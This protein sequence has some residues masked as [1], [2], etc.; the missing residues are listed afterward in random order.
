MDHKPLL[1]RLAP[2]SLAGQPSRLLARV[3]IS[4]GARTPDEVEAFLAPLPSIPNRLAAAQHEEVLSIARRI[5]D[6]VRRNETIVIFADYDADGATSAVILYDFLTALGAAPA[7][8]LPH[9]INEGYGLTSSAAIR[10]VREHH[11]DLLIAVDCGTNSTDAID[12]LRSEYHCDTIVIDHHS[13]LDLQRHPGLFLNPKLSP[14]SP[15]SVRELSA[16]GLT[17]LLV[18]AILPTAS[19]TLPF[20]RDRAII[21]AGIGTFVD[22]M[23]LTAINRTLVKNALTLLN[24]ASGRD[25]IPGIAAVLEEASSPDVDSWTLAFLLGPILNA[26]GRI[27]NAMRTIALLTACDRSDVIPLATACVATNE[28][29]KQIQR[30]ILEEAEIDAT[31]I[32]KNCPTT[33]ILVV[34]RAH[35]HTGIV[36]IVAARL[37]ERFHR[38]AIVLGALDD[39]TGCHWKGS[40]RSINGYDIGTAITNAVNSGYATTGGGHKMAGGIEVPFAGL[41]RLRKHLN[42]NCGLTDADLVPRFDVLPGSPQMIERDWA[43]LFESLEPFGSGNARP[44][45]EFNDVRIRRP[46][47]HL[48]RP[49]A[50]GKHSLGAVYSILVDVVTP[51][52]HVIRAQSYDVKLIERLTASESPL[53]ILLGLRRQPSKIARNTRDPRLKPV[54]SYRWFIESITPTNPS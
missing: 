54:V 45:I 38:P 49:T 13:P 51:D 12:L 20:D 1:N 19:A 24:T 39:A 31:A 6:A 30:D 9:R 36:G 29:R 37:R 50:R 46:V 42:E 33:P 35:W 15:E 18:D 52:G 47:I 44:C 8:F 22:V 23:P 32:L 5:Q 26:S 4:R 14:S 10:C 25:R 27:D 11:P 40:A 34:A 7:I 17:F 16:A 53:S 21:L 3:A 43:F 41:E 2:P 48:R 28:T